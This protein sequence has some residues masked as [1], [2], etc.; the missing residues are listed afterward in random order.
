MRRC[1]SIAVVRSTWVPSA[2]SMVLALVLSLAIAAPKGRKSL[3]M[4]WLI[5]T[6]R[7]ARNRMRFFCLAF[8][9]RQMIW[10]AV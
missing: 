6:L 8:Q 1:L 10:K 5:S 3:T 7:S 4:A 2:R 9:S